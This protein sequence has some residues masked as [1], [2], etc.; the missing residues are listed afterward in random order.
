MASDKT[1]D[2]TAAWNHNPTEFSSLKSTSICGKLF[3][4]SG[5]RAKRL[6]QENVSV[7]HLSLSHW[8]WVIK[9]GRGL[10]LPNIHMLSLPTRMSFTDVHDYFCQQDF[11]SQGGL[12][13]LKLYITPTQGGS[14]ISNGYLY[15]MDVPF[16]LGSIPGATYIDKNHKRTQPC[17]G[18]VLSIGC[19]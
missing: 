8:G 3:Y 4:Q 7:V 13:N 1:Q 18:S 5:L 6:P 17:A 14:L 12:G 10:A 9:C 16:M 11:N 19:G 15:C 2:L